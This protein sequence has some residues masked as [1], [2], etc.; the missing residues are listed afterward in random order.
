MP[1]TLGDRKADEARFIATSPI[2]QVARI[3]APV[4][5]M[6]GEIDKRVP[7]QSGER[8][9]D[10]LQKNGKQVE[11]VVYPDEGHGF[12]RPENLFDYWRRIEAFLAK[13]LK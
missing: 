7:I 1:I 13:H 10:A 3:K 8:M 6:H 4:L 2:E 12:H 9:R 5:L 11:W